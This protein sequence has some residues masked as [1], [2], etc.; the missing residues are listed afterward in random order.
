M[1]VGETFFTAE[2]YSLQRLGGLRGVLLA[3]LLLAAGISGCIADD[4]SSLGTSETHT[5]NRGCSNNVRDGTV[6]PGAPL[7]TVSEA[8][9][10]SAHGTIT[11]DTDP[12][13]G[14]IHLTL[15]HEEQE[16]WS[17]TLQ[18]YGFT[19]YSTQFSDLDAGNYTL[20]ASTDD[21]YSDAQLRLTITWGGGTCD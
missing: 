14:T 11:Y 19:S 20:T 13:A 3:L 15:T 6:T 21:G 8:G 17:H 18:G 5:V 1:Q 12:Q 10:G 16:T 2:T 9:A 7:T 4:G